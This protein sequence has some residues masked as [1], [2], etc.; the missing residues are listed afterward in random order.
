MKTKGA[1]FLASIILTSG[2]C[3][4]VTVLPQNAVAATLYVGGAGPGNYTLIQDA[5]DAAFPW[6]M[7]Y[8]YSG[9]YYEHLTIPKRL[10]L[11]GEDKTTTIID[12]SGTS[13]VVRISDDGV[14][15]TG[16]TVRNS[17]TGFGDEGLYL[18]MVQN[19]HI[20]GNIVNNTETGIFLR[21]S[22]Y[23]TIANNTV[24]NSDDGIYLSVSDHNTVTYN[25]VSSIALLGIN[26]GGSAYNVV[27]HN[28]ASSGWE[29][30][31]VYGSNNNT[32]TNNTAVNSDVGLSI[33][34]SAYT[35]AFN[36]TLTGNEYGIQI[37]Y[38]YN[39]TI[40]HNSISQSA[41]VGIYPYKTDN[42]TIE[43]NSVLDNKWGM[44]LYVSDNITIRSNKVS[45]NTD[46][47]IYLE[48]SNSS[49]ITGNDITSNGDIGCY[50][51]S[52]FNNKV[53]HNNL[54]DNSIFDAVDFMGLN[55]WDD[56]YPSGGNYWGKYSG[57]DE[58][59]GPNQDQPGYDGIGDSP[60]IVYGGPNEDRYPLMHP[61]GET[62]PYS[63]YKPRFVNATEGDEQVV[64]NWTAPIF[65]GGAPVTNYRI[66]RGTSIGSIQFLV[67]V[68]NALTYTDSP[69]TNGRQYYYRVSAKNSAGEGP[70]TDWISVIPNAPPNQRPNGI[71]T[72]PS[73]GETV[74]GTC[75]IEGDASDPD[76]TVERVDIRIGDGS[77][78]TAT[79]T[80]FWSFDWDTTSHSNGDYSI[81]IRIWD[82]QDFSTELSIPVTVDNP[83]D[84]IST[85]GW[86]PIPL[87]I[88]LIAIVIVVAALMLRRR[89][90]MREYARQEPQL[91]EPEGLPPPPP[92]MPEEELPPPPPDFEEDIPPPPRPE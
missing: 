30:L 16:F 17:G 57:E 1:F 7:I 78:H 4:A 77:W 29:A 20:E 88:V 28:H 38:D 64:L 11:I 32:V 34:S 91:E 53:Y 55:T 85:W 14:V 86:T 18:G 68:D 74:S 44:Y 23:N 10:S 3:L 76:G 43:N 67:E 41:K 90:K 58:K 9:T 48:Y 12:G 89:R 45:L 69:L 25:D 46:D 52:S 62:P 92:D 79:G 80:D 81:Q 26:V 13:T 2:F 39:N 82:G 60:Q 59:S 65:D 70:L 75:A 37:W 8:V 21:N 66:Y 22:H 42:N 40:A 47:G 87:L 61:S 19:C 6:D 71:V 35:M 83:D 36:N 56:G 15:F 54:L 5:I 31:S 84:P 49:T 24:Q 63:P 27:S 50:I 51:S 33:V 73:P 72:H